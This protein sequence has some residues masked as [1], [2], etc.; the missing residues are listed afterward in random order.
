MLDQLEIVKL[1]ETEI[2][3]KVE[4]EM[5]ALL[6]DDAWQE[7]VEKAVIKYAQDRVNAKFNSSEWAPQLVDAVENSV[8]RMFD[9]GQIKELS[10]II[11]E[12]KIFSIVDS[13]IEPIIERR[14]SDPDW[15]VKTQSISNQI[16]VSKIERNFKDL[17][18]EQAIQRSVK[19]T[20]GN[21]RRGI[22]DSS[23]SPQITITDEYVVN[24]NELIT[25]LLHTTE[26][27]QFDGD[28]TVN[29]TL[30]L[31]GKVNTDNESWVELKDTI[32]KD[33]VDNV[34][35]L[36]TQELTEDILGIAKTQGIEFDAV[37]INGKK[38]I[39]G[40]QL[41]PA[42]T[43][44][45]ITEVGRLAELEVQGFTALNN[46]TLTVLNTRVGINTDKPTM[47]LEIWDQEVSM[48]MGKVNKD[49]GFVGLAG[50]GDLH[51]GINQQ[52]SIRID[53]D[54]LVKI[55]KL[56]IGRN[57]VSWAD[58]VPGHQGLKGDIVFNN[59]SNEVTGW[60]CTGGFNWN[61]F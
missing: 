19:N 34:K 10:S 48:S 12:S 54:G 26:N 36:N 59:G 61:Q 1:V 7:V 39:D 18:V 5:K 17:N 52:G 44:T 46:D 53:Q 22:N 3:K 30:V 4:L 41:T 6:E 43:K 50:K 11:D 2:S 23:Q 49:T 29:G 33:V 60:R 32:T 16:A 31:K 45:K 25:R 38:L 14:F 57:N 40:D 56:R 13:K 20:I 27:A 51:I 58:K 9:S 21:L 55:N 8:K 28:I 47:A 15:N 42:I 35:A 24:E 37:M